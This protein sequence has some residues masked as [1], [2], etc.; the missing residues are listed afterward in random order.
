ML[1]VT[2]YRSSKGKT[3]H[4]HTILGEIH[5]KSYAAYIILY[6]KL[7]EQDEDYLMTKDW[8]KPVQFNIDFLKGRQ[9]ELGSLTCAYCGEPDLKI[10]E[11]D[12]ERVS[13]TRLATV[14]HF[15][16]Q[17]QGGHR[18]DKE[19]FV[20]CCS[21]CNGKKGDKIYNLNTLLYLDANR[22]SVIVSR[23]LSR[24]GKIYSKKLAK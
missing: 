5:P 16:A 19:I 20:E 22:F 15:I 6:Y 2:T 10:Q 23:V 21:K 12:G 3:R 13:K 18:F 8:R 14:D 4:T 9:K 17:A 1:K 7:R 24:Y 11:I